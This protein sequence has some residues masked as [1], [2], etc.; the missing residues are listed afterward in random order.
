MSNSFAVLVQRW[1][2][3]CDAG[4]ALNQHKVD[5][6]RLPGEFRVAG[7]DRGCAYTVL[8]T[9]QMRGVCSAVYLVLY[10]INNP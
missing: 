7:S 10:T 9:V 4:S 1:S 3:I 5:V 6:L 2:N 8:Q